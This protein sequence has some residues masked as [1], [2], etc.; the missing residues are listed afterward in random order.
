MT[1]VIQRPRIIRI[2]NETIAVL[3][4][5]DPDDCDEAYRRILGDRTK[6]RI[7]YAKASRD[8]K[9]DALD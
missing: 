5:C 1:L 6:R 2:I 3:L 7:E 9:G 4:N 8:F